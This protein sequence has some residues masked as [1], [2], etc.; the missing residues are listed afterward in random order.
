MLVNQ[1]YGSDHGAEEA[2]QHGDTAPG[3]QTEQHGG[4]VQDQV[5]AAGHQR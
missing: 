5:E 2:G 4:V 3:L 1:E